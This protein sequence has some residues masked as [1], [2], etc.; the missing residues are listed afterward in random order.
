VR[1]VVTCRQEHMRDYGQ[2]LGDPWELYLQRFGEQQIETYLRM[3]L[4]LHDAQRPAPADR[5]ASDRALPSAVTDPVTST[6]D[7]PEACGDADRSDLGQL[8]R[9]I[10]ESPIRRAYTVPFRLSMGTDLALASDGCERTAFRDAQRA[11]ELYETW[12]WHAIRQKRGHDRT[13]PDDIAAAEGLAWDLHCL[14]RTQAP[15]GPLG[16]RDWFRCLPLR[17]HDF[18]PQSH[19]S[20]KHKSLQEFLVARHLW[21]CLTRPAAT[22]G[23]VADGTDAEAHALQALDL[24]RDFPVLRFFG[25]LL[26]GDAD[27]PGRAR[28]QERLLAIPRCPGP[29]PCSRQQHL[30]PERRGGVACRPGPPGD[31]RPR[32][33][34]TVREFVRRRPPR[35]QPSGG[36]PPGRRAGLCRPPRGR[37]DGRGR[38]AAAADAGGARRGCS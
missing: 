18:H 37:S 24:R 1:L 7:G 27:K 22:G 5:P 25:D 36:G 31:P 20:F 33:C 14:H 35:G 2:C 32:G 28:A 13:I 29:W 23:G 8:L 12:L 17:V 10:Q 30:P 19:F 34:T 3:R 9:Q 38:L 6:G 26:H 4:R 11:S 15:V 21:R 16:T